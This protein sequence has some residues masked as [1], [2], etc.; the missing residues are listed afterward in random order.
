MLLSVLLVCLTAL[1][2]SSVLLLAL[3]HRFRVSSRVMS[4]MVTA[5]FVLIVGELGARFW[6]LPSGYV[7][8]GEV[9]L[10][11]VTL[12]VVLVRPLWNPPGHLFFSST[13][14]AAL[15]YLT[16]AGWVTVA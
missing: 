10:F 1:V 2:T 15:A 12:V 14:A 13:V 11:T 9:Y 7:V 4:V 8:V 16:L 6:L 5:P 3:G